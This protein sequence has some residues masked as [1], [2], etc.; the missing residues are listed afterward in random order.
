[1]VITPRS[2]RFCIFNELLYWS[3][4]TVYDIVPVFDL[5]RD[6]RW[7]IRFDE[8]QRV[9]EEV[10]IDIIGEESGDESWN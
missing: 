2:D 5:S 3:H 9:T 1:M 4:R 8:Q 10:L 6:V 7:D